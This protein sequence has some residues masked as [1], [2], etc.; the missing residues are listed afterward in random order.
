MHSDWAETWIDG[1]NNDA[2]IVLPPREHDRMR[3]KRWRARV[4]GE[5]GWLSRCAVWH[6]PEMKTR[7]KTSREQIAPAVFDLPLKYEFDISEQR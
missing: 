5:Y 4:A 7:N 3:G 2:T 6:R 1:R